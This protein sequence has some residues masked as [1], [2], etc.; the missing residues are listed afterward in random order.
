MKIGIDLGTANIMVF[1]QG[2]GIVMQEPS[3]VAVDENNN[4]V[5]V[6]VHRTV[7]GKVAYRIY[8]IL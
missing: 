5:A 6:G 2:Q 8:Q 7:P 4:I 3:V 1:V